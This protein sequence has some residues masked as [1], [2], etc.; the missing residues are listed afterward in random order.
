MNDDQIKKR[1]S[2]E[3]KSFDNVWGGG[4]FEGEVLNPVGHSTYGPVGY[5]SILHALY[6][7][8]IK[9]Y[10]HK[11]SIV[12]E[13]GP[14]RGAFT[15]AILRHEPKEVWCLDAVSA[16]KN[17]FNQYVGRHDNVKYTQVTDFSCS[18]LPDNHF[19]YLFSFGAL[20]H[21]SFDGITQYLTNL[22]PKLKSGAECFIMVADY[23]KFNSCMDNIDNLSIYKNLPFHKLISLNWELYKKRFK[24]AW[25]LRHNYPENQQPEPGRWFHAGIRQTCDLLVLLGYEVVSE[26][27][28]IVQRD[29]IIHFRK[30]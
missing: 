16:E 5:V 9:P 11:E 19:N 27:I 26:D 15:K 8:T 17:G 13:I 28:G 3:I 21:V 1:L 10:L 4:Y 6:L 18:M 30:K 2:E 25:A 7:M 24:K 14:G 22:Y 20:C 12:L 29:P 23:D